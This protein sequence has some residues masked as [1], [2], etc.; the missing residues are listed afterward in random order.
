MENDSKNQIDS[1][2]FASQ[3]QFEE[4]KQE[5][6][7]I[8]CEDNHQSNSPQSPRRKKRKRSRAK[9]NDINAI[10]DQEPSPQEVERKPVKKL[11]RM[12]LEMMYLNLTNYPNFDFLPEDLAA[13]ILMMVVDRQALDQNTVRPFLNTSHPL[14]KEFCKK[15]INLMRLPALH[16]VGCRGI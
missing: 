1:D 15:Y 16:K 8:T 6:L 4:S 9:S 3:L 5:P 12:C 11:S 2:H 10:L 13:E 7:N 14:I